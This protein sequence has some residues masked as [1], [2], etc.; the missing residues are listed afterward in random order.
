ML[1]LRV[2]TAVLLL[3]VLAPVFI[4]NRPVAR[5]LLAQ[6]AMNTVAGGVVL[7]MGLVVFGNDGKM[8]TYAALVLATGTAQF[9]GMRR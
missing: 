6:T 3:A 8:A 7:V 2:I 1:K 5:T 4:R 9:L